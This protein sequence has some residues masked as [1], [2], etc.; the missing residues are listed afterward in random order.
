M[1]FIIILILGYAAWKGWSRG[2]IMA[3]FSLAGTL[4]GVLAAIKFS[5]VVAV[6]LA[7]HTSWDG[8]WLPFLSFLI[9]LLLVT[10]VVNMAGKMVEATMDAALLGAANKLAGVVLYVI[11]YAFVVSMALYYGGKAGLIEPRTDGLA[12][13]LTP[14]AP[15]VLGFLAQ[16]LPF[17]REALFD[18][19]AWL[20]RQ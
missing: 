14:L 18:L 6:Y 17:L 19:E 20:G 13:M 2:F 15:K 7:E 9:V 11:L 4:L 3:L 12:G 5:A 16:W 10:M 8:K 1:D